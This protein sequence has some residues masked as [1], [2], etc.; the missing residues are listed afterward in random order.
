VNT[1]TKV[2]EDEVEV[3]DLKSLKSTSSKRSKMSMS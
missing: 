3:D 1:K 2:I